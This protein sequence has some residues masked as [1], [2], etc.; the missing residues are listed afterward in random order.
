MNVAAIIVVALFQLACS[1]IVPSEQRPTAAVTAPATPP[2]SEGVALGKDGARS[3]MPQI[4]PATDA[5]TPAPPSDEET[6]QIVL[7]GA[8]RYLIGLPMLVALTYENH[9]KDSD[10]FSLSAFDPTTT[11]ANLRVLMEPLTG[12][13]RL[14]TGFAPEDEPTGF[15]LLTG[16]SSRQLLDLSNLGVRFE[17]GVYRL[18]AALRMGRHARSSNS[19]ELE[20]APPPS[21][22]LAGITA[23]RQMGQAASDTGAWA[24]FLTR[25]PRAVAVPTSISAVSRELLLLHLFLHQAAYGQATLSGLSLEPLATIKEP[26]LQAECAALRYELL[27]SRHDPSAPTH[28]SAMLSRYAGLSFRAEAVDRGEGQLAQWRKAFGA[29]R[30]HRKSSIPQPHQY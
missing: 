6:P 4:P 14:E 26:S 25:N 28:R 8:Q 9:S 29:E 20:I 11:R 18:S 15:S 2:S 5:M 27:V 7:H 21:A 1:R 24:P 10:F 17:P 19:I 12:G 13:Q 30:Q 16:Q 22:D 23:L 3:I